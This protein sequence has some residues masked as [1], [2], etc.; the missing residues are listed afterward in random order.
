MI[1]HPTDE[2]WLFCKQYTLNT[3]GKT[4]TKLP[5]NEWKEKLL[6]SDAHQNKLVDAIAKSVNAYDFDV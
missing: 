5:T 2:D 3:I 6:K 4:T 1:K